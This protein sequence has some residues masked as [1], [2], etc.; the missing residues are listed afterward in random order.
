MLSEKFFE[1]IIYST[2]S[3]ERDYI[4]SLEMLS[5]FCTFFP[6]LCYQMMACQTVL[7]YATAPLWRE[8]CITA[9]ADFVSRCDK[10]AQNLL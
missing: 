4:W 2:I 5:Y 10:V 9:E 3:N 1:W 8:D 7:S 6:R